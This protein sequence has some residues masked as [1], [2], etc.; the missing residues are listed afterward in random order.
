MF[1]FSLL[2]LRSFY[3]KTLKNVNSPYR[4]T[5][6]NDTTQEEVLQ[7]QLTKKSVYIVF[8]S[9]FVLLFIVFSILIFFTPLKYYVP[10]TSQ[11]ISRK[12]M[13]KI[14]RLSDS[15]QK[16]NRQQEKYINDLMRITMGQVVKEKDSNRLSDKEMKQALAGLNAKI[17][18]ATNYEYLKVEEQKRN[19]SLRKGLKNKDNLLINDKQGQ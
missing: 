4:L 13:I 18:K 2:G 17:D 3:K 6:V 8:S 15:I 12:E 7:F 14:Q 9:L 1:H 16:K 5:L 10:G 11:S 19:D